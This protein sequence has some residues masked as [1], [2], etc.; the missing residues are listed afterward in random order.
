LDDSE[1]IGL[2]WMITGLD[3]CCNSYNKKPSCR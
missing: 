3:K 2:V 1:L